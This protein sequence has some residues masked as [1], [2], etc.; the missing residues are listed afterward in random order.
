MEEI[1]YVVFPFHI[2]HDYSD[3]SFFFLQKQEF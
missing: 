3:T 1:N 2:L